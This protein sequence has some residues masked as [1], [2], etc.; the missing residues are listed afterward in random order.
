MT[1]TMRKLEY[2]KAA[3]RYDNIYRAVWQNFSYLAVLSGGI[4]AFGTRDLDWAAAFFLALTPLTFWYFAQFHPMDH[5]GDETRKRLSAIEDDLNRMYFP[6]PTDLKIRHFTSFKVSKY[7][8]RVRNAVHVFGVAVSA[9][10]LLM[11]VLAVDRTVIS[12]KSAKPATAQA[13]QLEPQPFQI[14]LPNSGVDALRDSL[15]A[16]STRVHVVDSLVRCQLDAIKARRRP[17]C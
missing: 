6:L 9:T 4:L 17:A 7:R 5:Y 13:L 16:L 14:E 2:E 15:S 11:L 1:M 10:W 12:G 3:D 8:W